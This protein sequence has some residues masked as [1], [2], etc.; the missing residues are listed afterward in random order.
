MLI[1]ITRKCPNKVVYRISILL[2]GKRMSSDDDDH[3]NVEAIGENHWQVISTKL[4][5]LIV[6]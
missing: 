6:H 2:V 5:E 1:Y 3:E 4:H